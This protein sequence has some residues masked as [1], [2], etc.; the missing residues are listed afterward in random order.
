MPQ[1]GNAKRTVA[2]KEIYISPF[3]QSVIEAKINPLL[4]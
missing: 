3:P 4:P 2:G 1:L